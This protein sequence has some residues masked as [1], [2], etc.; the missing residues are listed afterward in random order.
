M[1]ELLN[2]S[3]LWKITLMF[4]PETIRIFE[5][6][7]STTYK[8]PSRESSYTSENS[9]AHNSPGEKFSYKQV[10]WYRIQLQTSHPVQSSTTKR[11][12]CREFS[13]KQV[14]L[15]RV[16]LQTSHLVENSAVNK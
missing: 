3:E 7:G 13:Y 15:W 14:T 5:I 9:A 8:S 1:I 4:V 10:T 11:L 12:Q 16:Q 2:V 6:M